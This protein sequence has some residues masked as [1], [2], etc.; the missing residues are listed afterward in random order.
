MNTEENQI[1]TNEDSLL[2][3]EKIDDFFCTKCDKV[4][5]PNKVRESFLTNI[6]LCESCCDEEDLIQKKLDE[7]LEIQFKLK[8]NPSASNDDRMGLENR[9]IYLK[10]EM[11][12]LGYKE[13]I[14]N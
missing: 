6:I 13:Y 3:E 4:T 9:I 5:D 12:Q 14:V 8:A 11:I 7:I 10:N 2:P 1:A